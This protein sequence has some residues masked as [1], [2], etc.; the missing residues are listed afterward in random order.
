MTLCTMTPS[1]MSSAT[2]EG[3]L[4]K[5]IRQIQDDDALEPA[6]KAQ[7]I[8]RLMSGGHA[9]SRFQ[10]AKRR[11]IEDVNAPTYYNEKQQILGCEHYQRKVKLQAN[12]CSEIFPCRFCHDRVSH[13]TMVRSETKNMKC[14]LCGALQPAAQSCRECKQILARYY[15]DLCK[16]WDDDPNKTSYHCDKCG[17]CRSGRGLGDDYF[18]CDTCNVCLSINMKN[19]HRCIERSLDNDCPIC[20]EY[21]FTSTT[22][23]YFMPCGHSIHVPCYIAHRETSYQC[24]TC[25]KSLGDM[26]AYFER[27]DQDIMQQPMPPEYQYHV[28]HIF[29]NDCE[30]RSRTK[31]HF[32]HHKCEN[33]NSYN[34]TVL[35]TEIIRP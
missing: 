7:R 23:S 17:L 26:T 10:P 6:E 19:N 22:R 34:T 2:P 18:H 14:M 11:S 30:T 35:Q 25:L 32:F 12:C 15:C 20:G 21:L 28:S 13:H 24:P 31:Y 4:R 27:V 1:Y 9:N 16:L 5:R 8:Q 3:E 29:C 33:C